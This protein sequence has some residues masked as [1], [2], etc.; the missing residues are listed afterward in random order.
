ML[1]MLMRGYQGLQWCLPQQPGR[2]RRRW[3]CS[4]RWLWGGARRHRHAWRGGWPAAKGAAQH[5]HQAATLHT[6][7]CQLGAALHQASQMVGLAAFLEEIA[8]LCC[9]ELGLDCG[10]TERV[11]HW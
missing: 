6:G 11:V 10:R 2:W 7:L 3:Q 9:A 8:G 5:L 4:A 1:K